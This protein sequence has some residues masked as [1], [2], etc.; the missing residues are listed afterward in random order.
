MSNYR[1]CSLSVFS[2][3]LAFIGWLVTFTGLCTVSHSIQAL[4]WCT[5]VFEFIL[6]LFVLTVIFSE[7]TATYHLTILSLIVLSFPYGIDEIKARILTGHPA[8]VTS[9]AGYIVLMIAKF[10]WIFLFGIQKDTSCFYPLKE[11]SPYSL[12][13]HS[14]DTVVLSLPNATTTTTASTVAVGAGQKSHYS[15]PI[16]TQLSY[17][18][19]VM[20]KNG[21]PSLNAYPNA[22]FHP[23]MQNNHNV[24]HREENR[25]MSSFCSS[26]NIPVVALHAYTANPED[27][28][29]LSFDKGERF[30]VQTR[31]GNWWKA[32]KENGSIGMIPS[33]YV[34]LSCS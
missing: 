30:N 34:A 29:E 12:D 2:C 17:P 3:T 9:S 28:H 33:N 22:S 32:Q 13:N 14:Y 15:H 6:L 24:C 19:P 1:L 4:S 20:S 27:P 11:Y 31:Q 16:S 23:V 10:S 25:I 7:S 18:H 8:L 5:V 21:C 26:Y